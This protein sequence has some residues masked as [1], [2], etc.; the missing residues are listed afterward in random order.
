MKIPKGYRMLKH[1]EKI[2]FGD[3]YRA[4]KLIH[5]WVKCVNPN[6]DEKVD[7]SRQQFVIRKRS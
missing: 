3:K 4:V 2:K 5:V 6:V 1:G 7:V